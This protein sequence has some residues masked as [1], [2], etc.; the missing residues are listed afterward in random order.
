MWNLPYDSERDGAKA[1]ATA[2]IE[3]RIT[4]AGNGTELGGVEVL[5]YK[6][7]EPDLPLLVTTDPSGHFAAQ[8]LDP[9]RYRLVA[10]HDGYVTQ[11]YGERARNHEGI[12]VSLASGQ[13][14]RDI[15]SAWSGLAW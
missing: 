5:A 8:D 10:Q 7:T 6:S 4:D 9:G 3:G 11:K 1:D 12:W 13:N 2:S 15:V 14:L